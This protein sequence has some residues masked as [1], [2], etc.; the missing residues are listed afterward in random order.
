MLKATDDEDMH[1]LRTL[2]EQLMD[3]TSALDELADDYYVKREIT[4]SQF[5]KSHQALEERIEATKRALVEMESGR[6]MTTVLT[7]VAAAE[8]V[9]EAWENASQDWRRQ[10]ID[11][12]IERIVVLPQSTSKFDPSSIQVTWRV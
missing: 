1:G 4:K 7:A 8:G 3:D 5:V 2:Y 9:R 10:L 6:F 12:L 11:A